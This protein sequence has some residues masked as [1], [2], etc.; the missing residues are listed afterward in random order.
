MSGCFARRALARVAGSQ[1]SNIHAVCAGFRLNIGG[2]SGILHSI[3]AI[4]LVSRH[5]L[6][7]QLVVWQRQHGRCTLPGNLARASRWVPWAMRSLGAS[8]CTASAS[9]SAVGISGKAHCMRVTRKCLGQRLAGA[10]SQGSSE[11][12]MKKA[13]DAAK[14]GAGLV[15]RHQACVVPCLPPNNAHP[16]PARQ[17]NQSLTRFM[18]APQPVKTARSQGIAR[19][20]SLANAPSCEGPLNLSQSFCPGAAS[21]GTVFWQ[22]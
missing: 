15:I 21:P 14:A 11:W 9:K 13:H 16:S 17:P 3:D 22:V 6:G 5:S 7:A 10:H 4:A 1:T 20:A 18:L 8:G 2:S 12:A 19:R